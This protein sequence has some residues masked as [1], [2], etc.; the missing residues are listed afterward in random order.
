MTKEKKH[1]L[2]NR[3]TWTHNWG[4]FLGSKFNTMKRFGLDGSEAFVPG[5]KTCIDTLVNHGTEK[6]VIGMPHRGRLNVL[7]NVVRKPMEI[8]M[9]EFQGIKPEEQENSITSGSGDVKYH[10]GTS[11]TK[12]YDN[13]K[14]CNVTVLANPSHLETVNPVLQGVARAE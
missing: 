14:E 11:F 12:K 7:A 10:L 2:F 5:L 8:I 9:A 3:L 4:A 1:Q 13:G 6:V